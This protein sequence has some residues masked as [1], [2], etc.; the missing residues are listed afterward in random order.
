MGGTYS[1]TLY[2]LNE[3]LNHQKFSNNIKLSLELQ[4]TLSPIDHI[5]SLIPEKA[6]HIINADGNV[7]GCFGLFG[8]IKPQIVT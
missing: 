4:T 2:D 1:I 5:L 8:E 3:Q 6:S 7:N